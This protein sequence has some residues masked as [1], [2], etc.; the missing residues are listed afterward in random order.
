M[1]FGGRV[2]P[3]EAER[4]GFGKEFNARWANEFEPFS[5][6][7][8]LWIGGGSMFVLPAFRQQSR[9][10]NDRLKGR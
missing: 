4:A 9:F 8:P 7:A 10:N 5:D 1:D 2:R 3:T 6:K